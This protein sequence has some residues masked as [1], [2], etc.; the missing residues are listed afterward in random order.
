MKQILTVY[1]THTENTLVDL[2]KFPLSLFHECIFY[3][4]FYFDWHDDN[5]QNG[6]LFFS[7]VFEFKVS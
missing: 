5:V 7:S 2:M 1:D 6:V 3:I 4:C